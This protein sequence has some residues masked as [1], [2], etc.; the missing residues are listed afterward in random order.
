MPPLKYP[1]RKQITFLFVS[2]QTPK[3]VKC[4]KCLQ[5][6]DCEFAYMLFNTYMPKRACLKYFR[7]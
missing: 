4:Y 5:V 1:T 6:A 7:G 3:T 2:K